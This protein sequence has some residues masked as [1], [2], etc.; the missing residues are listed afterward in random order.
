MLNFVNK[1]FEEDVNF[2]GATFENANFY[3]TTFQKMEDLLLCW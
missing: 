3:E 2:M 1:E